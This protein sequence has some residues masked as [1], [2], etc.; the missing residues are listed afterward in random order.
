MRKEIGLEMLVEEHQAPWK[1]GDPTGSIIGGGA[2]T[3]V[4]FSPYTSI[5]S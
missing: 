5:D 1:Q 3:I 4:S 2:L